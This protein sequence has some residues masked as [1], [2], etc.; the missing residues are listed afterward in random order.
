MTHSDPRMQQLY[1]NVAAMRR[2][3]ASRLQK[4]DSEHRL[5]PSQAELLMIVVHRQP[6]SLKDLA[7]EM[8]LTPGSI[9]QL[10]EPLEQKGLICREVSDI[11]RRVTNIVTTEKGSLKIAHFRKQHS[12]I[13][14]QAAQALTDE[15]LDSL[16]RIQGKMIDYLKQNIDTPT[17]NNKSQEA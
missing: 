12:D 14:Q 13:I 15:E 16:L 17:Q 4:G 6:I 3:M 9:T 10:V 5:P 1:A 2:L 8:Q 11:D 7:T